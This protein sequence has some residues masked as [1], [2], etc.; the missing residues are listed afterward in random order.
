MSNSAGEM[1]FL[2][3]LEELRKRILLS[4]VAIM[5]GFGLGYW[6]TTHYELIKLV[7]KPVQPFIP[8]GKLTVLTLTD[9]F[10]IV[11]K[12][13]F[14][15]GVVLASPFVIYQI[16][17][18]LSPALTSREKRAVIPS[19]AIGFVL[20]AAG[21]IIGWVLVVP[22]GV[23]WLAT[24]QLGTFTT[25]FTYD[26]YMRLV[27][28][29]LIGMGISAELPL[30]M[31]LLASLNILSYRIYTKVRRYAVLASFVGGAILAPTPEVSM[32]ILFT[33]PLLLLYEVGVAG[34]W[35][36]ERRRARAARIAAAVLLIV[37]CVPRGLHAQVPPP[38]AQGPPVTQGLPGSV[39]TSRRVTGPGVRSVD[40]SQMKRLGLPSAPSYTFAQPDA[41][42]QALL[43]REG[44]AST[45]Y[46]GDSVRYV[47]SDGRIELEG[48][49]A[50]LR[51]DGQ[52]EADHILYDNALCE[53][54]ARGQ[55]RM[56]NH[57]QQPVIAYEMHVKICSGAERGVLDRAYTSLAQGGTNWFMR[58][59]LAIDSSGKRLFG[60]H[61]EFT[62]CDLPDPHYHF[63][64]G[65]VKWMSQSM[66]VA[67]PA[68]LYIRDVPVA[69]LPFIFQ[70]TKR[71]RS[72]GILIPR[73]GFNDIVRT[74]KN[75]NR[76]VSNIGYYWAPNDYMDATASL[77]WYANRY[78]QYTANVNYRWLDQFINGSVRVSKQIQSDGVASNTLLLDH[79][80]SF[81]A[82][83]QLNFF[84]NYVSNSSVQL[85]NAIDPLASTQSISS[86]VNFTKRL[87]WGSIT[88]GA[89]RSQTLGTGTGTMTLPSLVISPKPIQ[90]GRQRALV[91]DAQ[92][93]EHDRIQQS[94]GAARV[95]D[96]SDRS[97]HTLRF[98]E[99]SRHQHRLQHADH[100]LLAQFPE[101]RSL[102]RSGTRRPDSHDRADPRSHARCSAG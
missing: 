27:V 9:P 2:D 52:L 99:Q 68:V 10:M 42:M 58:G 47:V 35:I 57:G 49:A 18:F 11:L 80:Q 25:Q 79:R 1:P 63:D 100:I 56:F 6:L 78:T 14:I 90:F 19:L 34:A 86:S 96:H 53:V 88:A 44:F 93:D 48:H 23:E 3:H 59:N 45:R 64:A 89:T 97:G 46:R 95:A 31:I 38:A 36:V 40:T 74:D 60:A 81:N 50:T 84:L 70:D 4:L 15:L 92:P 26:S 62:S 12:F 55:P 30:V 91:A 65:K 101:S 16:W 61:T 102:Q 5:A 73:F 77:D 54:I 76:T 83:T 22:P 87:S 20:F 75:Y 71:D 28:H 72:S 32:M 21:V 82:T 33:I 94:V 66:I 41:I 51:S 98:H 85:A 29:L 13:A 67:R 43:A 7:E 8:G 24:Y 17:L 69:W 37:L 39:D